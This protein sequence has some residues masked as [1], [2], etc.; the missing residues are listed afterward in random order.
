MSSNCAESPTLPRGSQK[1]LRLPSIAS[2][3]GLLYTVSA[4]ALLI[5]SAGFLYWVL[6]RN[7]ER[8]ANPFLADKIHLLQL[9][10]KERW[11]EAELIRSEVQWEVTANRFLHHYV[12]V[13]DNGGNM[14]LETPN[15]AQC[16]GPG[17]FPPPVEAGDSPTGIRLILADGRACLLMSAS[18]QWGPEAK[19][20]RIVQVALDITS[21]D[22]LLS[23]YRRKLVAVLV[24][25]I[26]LSSA[27]GTVVAR[28]G[29]RPLAGITLAIQSISASQ[30]HERIASAGWPRELV[31]L[32]AEFDKMLDRLEGSF[33]RLS[34]FSADLAHELR[35]PINNLRGE[36][37]VA[38]SQVRTPEQHRRV[39]ESSL[40]EYA[41]LSRLIDNLLFL[42]RADAPMTS[43]DH[44][45]FNARKAIEVV[46][47]YYE[48]FA[49][50]RDVVVICEGEGELEA[51]LLLF[52]Q[53]MSNLL[54]NALNWTSRGGKV[55][56]SIRQSDGKVEIVVNDSGCGI[57]PEH[58]PHVF[59]RLYRVEPARAL[60]P[61]GVG[62][63][64]AIVKSIMTLHGGTI[65]V[66]SAVGKGTRFK[67]TFPS[68]N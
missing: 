59:D 3:L 17:G 26:L 43:V 33:Q 67:M 5:G 20:E 15:M 36:A 61:T 4:S 21:D 9:M 49:E 8:E 57:A 56:I 42:A 6:A 58:L 35:T 1:R 50:D 54:S 31:A 13:L 41:R 16:L 27:A 60:H 14:L 25:G 28:R 68:S 52:Q 51:D 62:I 34:Q 48:A 29:M 11:R 66:Q 63:G 10:L 47:E 12:R 38:L 22:K 45:R 55:T 53:A 23:D 44:S 30:L 19:T 32:A 65:E 2:R 37:G 7:L 24:L 39:L 18:A 46:R 64:L 40:E